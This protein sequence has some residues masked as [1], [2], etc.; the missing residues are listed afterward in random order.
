MTNDDKRTL[1]VVPERTK[2]FCACLVGW[3]IVDVYILLL[4]AVCMWHFFSLSCL[5]WIRSVDNED[6]DL[7]L[8]RFGWFG[9]LHTTTMSLFPDDVT[10][11]L[12]IIGLVIDR[13][14]PGRRIQSNKDANA[15]QPQ[16]YLLH[17]NHKDDHGK[18]TNEVQDDVE[19]LR[20]RLQDRQAFETH[21]LRSLY[22]SLLSGLQETD[23]MD[24]ERL[25]DASIAT[26][27][28]NNDGM[29]DALE[30]DQLHLPRETG[31]FLFDDVVA[32]T[33]STATNKQQQ[34]Q[35]QQ[36]KE[37]CVTAANV[38]DFLNLF[39][40]G[41]KVVSD[42]VALKIAQAGG[43]DA[44]LTRMEFNQAFGV[45]EPSAAAIVGRGAAGFAS[46]ALALLMSLIV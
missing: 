6:S 13:F 9:A 11:F 27:D 19:F 35:Q 44:C 32:C 26:I 25:M 37:D 16:C 10:D 29:I 36:D 1:H 38:V 14:V 8:L 41:T 4:S 15:P 18:T 20:E 17:S 24:I 40:G 22:V 3:I 5:C 23:H 31:E 28:T 46:I 30:M 2:A 12:P 39:Y 45:A 33:S 42:D 43:T 34:Q 21:R 7:T